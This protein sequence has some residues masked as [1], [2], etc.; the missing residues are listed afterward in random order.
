MIK[1]YTST[2]WRKLLAYSWVAELL[3]I[4]FIIGRFKW[5]GVLVITIVIVTFG[6]VRL[7]IGR[8]FLLYNMR[9][10]EENIWGKSLDRENW[11]NERN[12]RDKKTKRNAN[13]NN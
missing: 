4:M 11:K 10:L 6:L 12:E 1:G 7:Y 13:S 8:D 2:V 9:K 5:A 3:L